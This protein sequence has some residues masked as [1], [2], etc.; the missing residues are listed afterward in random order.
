MTRLV[1][2]ILVTAT[3]V[4][5]CGQP[6]MET[7]PRYE[8]YEPASLWEDNQSARRPPPGTVARDQ[9]LEATPAEL[10]LPITMALLERGKSQ[11][12]IN[13]V[14]CHG[15]VGYGEGMGVQ[16]GFPAPPSFH[17][18]RLRAAPLR[19]FY[20]VITDG[21]GVM[22]SYADRVQPRDRWAVAAYIRALQRSQ[23]TPLSALDDSARAELEE[24]P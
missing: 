21:Y 9:S 23:H 14:P 3:A 24:Q 4:G 18:P 17:N 15:A 1:I 5:A 12:E 8:T 10:P 2:V 22:Y 6:D 20:D 11:Y 7:Q 19:Y 16:R 13:C